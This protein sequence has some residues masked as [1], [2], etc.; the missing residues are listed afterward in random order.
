MSEKNGT[1]ETKRSAEK[2]TR[3]RREPMER[4]AMEWDEKEASLRIEMRGMVFRHGWS[5]CVR[6]FRTILKEA[7]PY[8]REAHTLDGPLCDEPPHAEKQTQ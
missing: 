6:A 2:N 3:L 7:P 1:P 5:A 4:E 8:V